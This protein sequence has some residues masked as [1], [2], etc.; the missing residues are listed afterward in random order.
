[1]YV[2]A[3]VTLRLADPEGRYAAVRLRSDLPQQAFAR[4]GDDWV[5]ELRIWPLDR[6]EYQLEL[7]HRGG[8]RELVCDP[9]NPQRAPGAFDGERWPAAPVVL[10]PGDLLVLYTD[11]V[12]DAMG[13]DER[14]G[15][16]RLREALGRL[17]GAAGER[18]L[19]LRAEL[20]AF[21]RGPQRDDTTVLVLQYRGAGA[22]PAE[23]SR[24]AASS[25]TDA[26][27]Q[28]AKRT[29]ERPASSSS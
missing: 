21:E 28:N 29:S 22:Q 19:A 4:E 20:E 10:E 25:I 23:A 13:E 17:D 15:E 8:D 1:M 3:A 16:E 26:R 14:F 24:A 5:L 7:E 6:L 27:L 18:L 12:T 11:G 2:P 9:D